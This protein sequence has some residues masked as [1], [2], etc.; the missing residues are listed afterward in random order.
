MPDNML[1]MEIISLA[2]HWEGAATKKP[3]HGA[4]Q[5]VT[6]GENFVNSLRADFRGSAATGKGAGFHAHPLL[7]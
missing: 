7:S 4:G 6:E 3:G 1:C 5:R 2:C